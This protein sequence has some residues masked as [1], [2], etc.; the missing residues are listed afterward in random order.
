[1]KEGEG[2]GEKQCGNRGEECNIIQIFF[3]K[4]ME[5]YISKKKCCHNVRKSLMATNEKKK[6]LPILQEEITVIKNVSL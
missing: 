5:R 4:G 6:K 3:L 2:R 1:M